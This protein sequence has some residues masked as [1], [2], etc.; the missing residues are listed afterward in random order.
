MCR[1]GR[2]CTF[3]GRRK[4]FMTRIV[5]IFGLISGA[6]AAAL[7]W[8]L[9]QVV[10]SGTINFENG[11]IWGYASM[12]IALSMV[13]FGVKSY[14]D[15]NGGRITFWK[16]LQVGILISLICAVCYAASWELYYPKIGDEFIQKYNAAYLDKMK[17]SGAS[18]ADIEKQRTESGKFAEMYRNVFVRFPISMMEILPVGILVTLI[19][20]ALLR[21]KEVLPAT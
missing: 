21:K 13:F 3:F 11:M 6:V 7:M 9:M 17:A 2:F 4:N 14:R 1:F 10:N 8:I 19:S 12:I 20:A 5:L 15:N 16:G 18:D